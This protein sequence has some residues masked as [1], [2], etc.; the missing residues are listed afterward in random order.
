MPRAWSRTNTQT[1]FSVV[2]VL[3]AVT[4][5]GMLVTALVGAIIYARSSTATAG[6]RARA[7]AIAEEGLEAV[8]TIRDA[9]FATLADGTYGLAQSANQWVFSGTQ[10]TTDVY[11]RQII[12]TSAGTNRKNVTSRVSWPQGATTAQLDVA[13]LFT[14]RLAAIKS[15]VNAT[16]SGSYDAAS[17]NNAIKVV[18]SGNY[19]Y[20]VR[21]DGTPDFMVI[22]ITNPAS[23]TLVGSLSLAGTPTNV[24]V[25][26][27]YAYVTNTSDTTELQIVN[28]TNPASPSL[29]SSFNAAGTGDA[30]GVW[31]SGNYAYMVRNSNVLSGEFTV[32]NISNP[33]SPTATG[34]YSNLVN[35]RDI[36]V[37]G[38]YAYI[39]TESDTQELL[40][41]NIS[42]PA[43]PALAGGLNLTGT[44]NAIAIDGYGNTVLIGQGAIL[45]AVNV[46]TPTSPA[47]LGSVTASGSGVINGIDVDSTNTYAFIG[48]TATA[49]EFQVINIANTASMNVADTVDVA[50][51]TSTIAGVAYSPTYEVVVGASA[52]D[53]QEVVTFVPN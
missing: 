32:V 3:L 20:V 50:G 10:D 52:S 39:A 36:W 4:V 45:Y 19:A 7:A 16:L 24:F 26:G 48:T 47:Q 40:V 42:N 34:L 28:I 1:G 43:L 37:S 41:L 49:A 22:N 51:T 25:S 46:T 30:N 15:W 12:V 14:N 29:T 31:V 6:N 5:F 53:T 44:N 17:T 11:T 9:N 13:S 38:N 18:V 35:L 2:E 21:A 8:R 27:N 23:P 33:A